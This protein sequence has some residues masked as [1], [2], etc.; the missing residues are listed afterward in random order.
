MAVNVVKDFLPIGAM[1][2]LAS[3]DNENRQVSNFD[4]TNFITY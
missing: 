4:D 1:G 3:Y 2:T